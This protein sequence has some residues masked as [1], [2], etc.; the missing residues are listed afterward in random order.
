MVPFIHDTNSARA[1]NRNSK[2]EH[3]RSQHD[4]ANDPRRVGIVVRG[5]VLLL[6]SEFVSIWLERIQHIGA[7]SPVLL[8]SRR[9]RVARLVL[10]CEVRASLPGASGLDSLYE[11]AVH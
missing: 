7:R 11:H 10:R 2:P 9:L 6:Q 3:G 1:A 4:F 5:A 8:D